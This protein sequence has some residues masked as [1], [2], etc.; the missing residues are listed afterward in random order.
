[1][2]AFGYQSNRWIPITEHAN[3]ESLVLLEISL[4][5]K[6]IKEQRYPLLAHLK[7]PAQKRDITAMH[8]QLHQINLGL[9]MHLRG[10]KQ[11]CDTFL[12]V[13]RNSLISLQVA[14]MSRHIRC[15]DNRHHDLSKLVVFILRPILKKLSLFD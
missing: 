4:I 11:L 9:L 5:E 8:C 13:T 6:F 3:W 10:R 7:V 15:V 14:H 2:L 12:A 1:M